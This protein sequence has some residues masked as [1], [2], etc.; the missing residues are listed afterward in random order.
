MLCSTLQM[1]EGSLTNGMTWQTFV[2]RQRVRFE[3]VILCLTTN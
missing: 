1:L 2:L 3:R